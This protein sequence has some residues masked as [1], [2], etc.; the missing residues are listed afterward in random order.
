MNTTKQKKTC[1]LLAVLLFITL[2]PLLLVGVEC[3]LDV[4]IRLKDYP[5]ARSTLV[6]GLVR[7]VII[8]TIILFVIVLFIAVRICRSLNRITGV[9][10]DMAEGRLNSHIEERDIKSVTELGVLARAADTLSN[11]LGN[12]VRQLSRTSSSMDSHSSSLNEV[13][14]QT[15]S[16][17]SDVSQAIDNVAGSISMQ[18]Q[19]TQKIVVQMEK[20]NTMMQES[21]NSLDVFH[22]SMDEMQKSGNQ[23]ISALDT[24]TT[25]TENTKA[26]FQKISEQT[27]AANKAAQDIHAATDLIASIASQTNLLALNASIEAA[28][29]GE[30]GRGFAVVAEQIKQLAEQ[31]GN[32]A[33]EIEKI[34]GILMRESNKT[35]DGMNVVGSIIDNQSAYMNQTKEAFN[36]VNRGINQAIEAEKNLFNGISQLDQVKSVIS[37]DLEVLSSISQ[38][39]AAAAEEI[40]A[41]TQELA[42]TI[43]TTKQAANEINEIANE[44]NSELGL[45][46]LS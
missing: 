2:F 19:S 8:T 34:I 12:I 3:I 13:A 41:S 46:I 27:Q 32:S 16:I 39:N 26:E 42:A 43:E 33:A 11:S 5:E 36:L 45:F 25:S 20:I 10:S 31:S 15:N 37:E 9:L 1:S 22:I 30:A 29:A 28:R 18:A 44:L 23:G 21:M 4:V 35:V 7:I 38:E 6:G 14:N 40:N 24:L 17:S